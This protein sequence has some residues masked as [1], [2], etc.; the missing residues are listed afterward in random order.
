MNIVSLDVNMKLKTFDPLKLVA[1]SAE[2][3]FNQIAE[4]D[5]GGIGAFWS[6]AGDTSPWEMHPD[7]DELLHV[8]E[9]AVT[10]EVLP[11]D[12]GPSVTQHIKSGAYCVVPQGCWHR[13]TLLKRTKE[14]YLTPGITLH[15]S[16]AD[17]R[18]G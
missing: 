9:G 13:Q 18:V 4:F 11:S 3:A 16:A 6:E 5:G 15:S 1:D 14:M 2:M 8:M 10:L 7:C 12:G 17:P